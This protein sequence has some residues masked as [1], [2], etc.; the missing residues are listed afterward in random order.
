MKDARIPLRHVP[1]SPGCIALLQHGNY[2]YAAGNDVFSVYDIRKADSPVLIR[3]RRGFGL[4]RQ[5][6]VSGNRLY[7]TAREYG[8]WIFDISDPGAPRRIHRYDTVELAT[9][10]A[11]A[12]DLVFI[13]QR[14]F[15]VEILDCSDPRC[16]RHLS[17]TRTQEAQSA[18]YADGKLYIGNWAGA[19]VQVMDVRDPY[20][21]KTVAAGELGGFGDG[22]AVADGYCYA[23]TGLNAKGSRDNC[24]IGNGHGLDIF[25]IDGDHLHHLSRVSFP[26]LK[27][28]SNDFWTVRISGKT[29]FVAD[30][31]NGVFVIDVSDPARP[32]QTGH[33]VLPEVTRIDARPEGQVTLRIPDCAGSIAVGRGVLYIAGEKTGLHVAKIRGARAENIPETVLHAPAKPSIPEAEIPGFRQYDPGGQVRRVWIEGKTLYTACSHA[34]IRIFRLNGETLRETK[35]LPVRCSYDVVVRDGLLYSAEGMDGLAVYAI[36]DG[37]RELGRWKRSGIILQL[38]HLSDNGRFAA[39]GSRG[40]ILRIFNVSNPAEIRLSLRHLHGGQMYGD[41]FPEHDWNDRMPMIWPYCGLSWYD[42]SGPKARRIRDDRAHGTGQTQGITRLHNRFLMNTMENSFLFPDP[43]D[44]GETVTGIPGKGCDGVPSADGD[45]VAFSCRRDGTVSLFR[46]RGNSAGEIPERALSG[47]RGTPDRIR[48]L[49]GRMVIPCG[50]QGLL[51]ETEA[52]FR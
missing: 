47:L 41:T 38:I 20:H 26:L 24:L 48:F 27:V 18:A 23:A 9:G 22:V 30:T 35:T 21:P 29:A 50:H 25:R 32:L 34:G 7:L 8:M 13:L 42:F 6:A 45:L 11:A 16:P 19:N 39:C 51:I 4:C 49:D 10:I 1:D 52:K 12:G 31:H 3:K 44:W 17:L 46:F 14:I 43:S 15:G 5:F 28:K 33:I 36:R 40:G 37:F 2:L